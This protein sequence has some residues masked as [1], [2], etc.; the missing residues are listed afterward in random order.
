MIRRAALLAGLCLAAWACPSA[1]Q[2]P[3]ATFAAGVPAAAPA[4]FLQA[5]PARQ[6]RG[7]QD[8][9]RICADWAAAADAD[10]QQRIAAGALQQLRGMGGA[11]PW[12]GVV[13]DREF[14]RDWASVRVAVAPGVTLE[15]MPTGSLTP[16]P[17]DTRLARGAPTFL[18]MAGAARGAVVAFDFEIIRPIFASGR[19]A[20]LTRFVAIE[21]L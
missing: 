8:L 18:A 11:T 9:R 17:H 16:D 15:T 1:A 3:A 13:V 6:R 21:R 12:A 14:S 10:R 20:F 4:D 5:L 2:A 7:V 19:C